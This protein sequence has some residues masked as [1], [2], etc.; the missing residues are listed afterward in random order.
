[1]KKHSLI[2]LIIFIL[3][4]S[5]ST[6]KTSETLI[7]RTS[8]LLHQNET[9]STTWMNGLE[10]HDPIQIRSD[11]DF[12]VQGWTGDGSENNPFI[13]EE[14]LIQTEN[15]PISIW[16]TTKYFEIRKCLLTTI[17]PSMEGN[18]AI[19]FINVTH[20]RVTNCF[21][22]E[23]YIGML[24]FQSTDCQITHNI[25]SSSEFEGLFFDY[26][27]D[28]LVADNTIRAP[29]SGISV[30]NS[31]NF[32]IRDN[33]IYDCSGGLYLWDVQ[34]CNITRNTI[35]RNDIGIDLTRG[36]SIITNN[37]IYG[38]E[39]IG[40]RVNSGMASNTVYENRIG[41]NGVANAQDDS[42][43]T[44]WDDSLG[45]GNSW[46]D[47][48]ETGNYSI[49]GTANSSDLWPLL[50]VDNVNPV[51]DS[52]DDVDFE[53]GIKGRLVIW[54]TSD[55]YPLR[56]QTTKNS[57]IT[58]TGTWGGP[59]FSIQLDDLLPGTYSFLLQI[60]DAK[61]NYAVDQVSVKIAKA[62]APVIN[63]PPDIEYVVGDVG[64]NITWIP[65]D[66]YPDQFEVYLNG[67]LHESGMWNGSEIVVVVD[68]HDVG[69]NNYSIVVYD[70][71]GQNTKDTVFVEVLVHTGEPP[72]NYFQ[73]VLFFLGIGAIGF[74]I[75]SAILYTIRPFQRIIGEKD[76]STV[77]DEI[78]AAMDELI[79]NQDL[80]TETGDED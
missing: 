58:E 36:K 49:L 44:D 15:S 78:Q 21:I 5:T 72:P 71:L 51:V 70:V 66:A 79:S 42:N 10:E 74:I 34:L 18:S 50:F 4:I 77:G 31:T 43:S 73:Q 40:I 62:E 11:N 26:G 6:Q 68:G 19:T 38:N 63:S 14:L 69:I 54:Y 29:R 48:S 67:A 23:T 47:W 20:G 32:T 1:M 60:W 65:A 27:L 76:D 25:V 57:E 28:I 3:F 7:N 35:W 22:N 61:G 33:R 45:T 52:P 46:S 64:Y 17:V 80:K 53:Y 39:N 9:R 56:Y 55:E 37:S 24:I 12:L 13:I 59:I 2:A 8:K 75:T 41:W 30:D 16:H